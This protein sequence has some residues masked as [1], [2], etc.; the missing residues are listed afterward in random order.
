MKNYAAEAATVDCSGVPAGAG[1]GR[2]SAIRYLL[3]LPVMALIVILMIVVPALFRS[4]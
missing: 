1:R 2:L 4:M 3:A